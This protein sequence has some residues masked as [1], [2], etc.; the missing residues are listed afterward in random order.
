M[1]KTVV[2]KNNGTSAVAIM[3]QFENVQTGFEDMSADDLQ[4]P[5]LKLLQAMSP[6][7]END[8]SLRS[9]HIY[10]SVTGEW[11]PADQGVK[12][13]P[14]VYHKTYVEWAPVGSGAKGPVA[15]HQSKD[16]MNNTV[17][18]DDNKYYTNDNS[19]NYIEETAN[20][21]VLIIGGKGETSQAVISMKSS[22]LTPSRNWNSK[23]KNLKIKNSEG[24][25]F[26][27]PMWS[28]SYLLKSEKTKNGDKTWYKWKIEVDSMLSIEAQVKE[29]RSFSEEMALAK[30]KLVPDQE[31][32]TDEKTP[33]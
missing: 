25:H 7:I 8:E 9:G 2:K 29:A 12:V 24:V 13:I 1:N 27:P 26:T 5:R 16:V 19:G 32:K 11:W 3:N 17:R 22:Q 6:E 21:F 33:F 10:N 14:C 28:H 15:V 30:D 20:Y 18:G 4:L 23:M 31:E